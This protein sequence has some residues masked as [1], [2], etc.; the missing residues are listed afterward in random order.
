MET[1]F[2]TSFIPKKP[3]VEDRVTKP[4][5]VG[6]LTIVSILVLFTAVIS[7]GG[8]YFYKGTLEKKLT[9][10]QNDLTLAQGRFEPERIAQLEVLN[11][12]LRAGNTILDRHVAISPIFEAL[13]KITMK[14]VR[15]SS[16]SYTLEEAGA[17][18]KMNVQMK[19]KATDYR[20]IALQSDLIN[21]N[22]YFKNPVFSNLSLD[23]KGG[24]TFELLFS[25]DPTFV[26]Y[27]KIIDGTNA[28]SLN[29]SVISVPSSNKNTSTTNNVNTSTATESTTVTPNPAPTNSP[30]TSAPNTSTQSTTTSN[31]TTP[32]NSTTPDKPAVTPATPPTSS[33]ST[34]SNSINNN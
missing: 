14:T 28:P 3:I 12:R 31:N 22:K 7:S 21:Q 4:H 9:G 8:V 18:K 33:P 30:N 10:M 27:G 1:N 23:E 20:S 11:R 2:Q 13:E 15:F 5:S 6:F 26:N 24:V 29:S 34:N 32:I 17:D 16:F 19:G 25:V